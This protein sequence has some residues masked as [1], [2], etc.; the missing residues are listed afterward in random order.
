V[1]GVIRFGTFEVNTAAGELRKA[2]TRVRLQDKPFQLLLLLL[3]RPG[4]IVSREE[5]QKKLWPADTFVDFDHSL[6]TAIAKL[7]TAL[8]DSA[9]SPI[10][11]ETVSARGYKFIAPIAAGS[12]VERANDVDPIKNAVETPDPPSPD[13][14]PAI[15]PTPAIG[16]MTRSAAIGFATGVA[17]LAIALWMDFFGAKR[18]L[19]RQT[20]RSIESVVVLPLS[21]HSGN[22][23][24]EYFAD[25]MTEQLIAT[26][27]QLREVQVTSRTSAMHYKGT[28]LRVPEIAR[29][30]NVDAVV[31]GSV[32]RAGEHIRV[33]IQLI[34][35]RTDQH[36]WAQTYERDRVDVL[37]LEGEIA[38]A[39]ASELR[40]KITPTEQQDLQRAR[41]VDPQADE[42]YLMGRFLMNKGTEADLRRSLDSFDRAV[43]IDP[44]DARSYASIAQT[45]IALTDYYEAPGTVMPAA[46]AAAQ[47]A[48]ELDPAL[49]DGHAALGA[50]KFL[51]DWDFPA[52]EREMKRA[53]EIAHAS[54]DA[55]MWYGVFLAQMGRIDQGIAEARLAKTLDP[56]SISVRFNTGWVYYL[57][58]RNDEA[59][60][61]WKRARELDSELH[62]VHTSLWLAYAQKGSADPFVASFREPLSETSPLDAATLAGAYAQSGRRSDA[63]RVLAALKVMAATRYVCP[64]E[65]ATVCSIL[66][67]NDEAIGWLQKAVNDRS[68]CMPDMKEDPRFDSLRADPRFAELLQ[69][70]GFSK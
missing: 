45:Y 70:V 19:V 37:A 61:E 31:E 5:V 44:S 29:E 4:E 56:L 60:A 50:V 40:V 65:L 51:Y 3:E 8:G 1:A 43:S 59:I 63:E 64:Y 58:R 20:S 41:R 57:A 66:G 10:Y 47:R 14:P 25:G 26:L 55:H 23:A 35:A 69:R 27:S 33:S 2:G 9:R 48:V 32:A 16:W 18:W 49:S 36:V 54:A 13:P 7:R 39:V 11:I 68:I 12:P 30:L 34:D 17:I 21:N 24:D 67:R 22:S 46:R 62:M 38:K 6:G 52:A 28:Q 15:E 42:A 53:T